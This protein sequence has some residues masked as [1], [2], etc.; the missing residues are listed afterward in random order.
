MINMIQFQKG[1]SLTQFM[2]Q[3]GTEAQCEEHLKQARWPQGYRCPKCND[4]HARTFRRNAQPYWQCKHCGY[5]CSLRAGTL[6]EHSHLP[7][8][9][10]YQAIY[11]MT[12]SKNSIAALEMKRQLGISWHA[13]WLL[14]HKLMEA[15]RQREAD[16]PLC[17]D[18]R[19]DDAY[20][21]GEN[22]GD[23]GGRKN[24]TAFVAA[25]QMHEGRPQRVRFDVVEGF[26]MDALRP[27]AEQA[28][29]PGSRIVSDGLPGFHVL[30]RMDF[31][32]T[33]YVVP[34]GKAGTE[35]EAFRWLNVVLGNLKRALSGTYHAF[36]FAKYAPRY[37]AQAQYCFNRRSDLVTMVPRLAFAVMHTQPCPRKDIIRPAEVRT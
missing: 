7:L 11:L 27:W 4:S 29:V 30:E 14:K 13:A 10:W 15:M 22:P 3:Y 12:Q 35:V 26:S 31:D 34:S 2:Q 21:G 6:M 18:V 37:L 24:K 36:N 32:R 8:S 16:R 28:L 9:I 25:V 17:G 20:L 5:Q 19:V 33:V 1:L 23:K